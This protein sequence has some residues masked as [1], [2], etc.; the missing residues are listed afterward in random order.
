MGSNL[1][2]GDKFVPYLVDMLAQ[3]N[4]TEIKR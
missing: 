2:Y 1:G 4:D 3:V